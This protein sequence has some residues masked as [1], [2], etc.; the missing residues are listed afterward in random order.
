M[1][2]HEYM[3]IAIDEV[4]SIVWQDRSL[5]QLLITVYLVDDFRK[6]NRR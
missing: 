3:T 2:F 5:V 1:A 6:V 4:L